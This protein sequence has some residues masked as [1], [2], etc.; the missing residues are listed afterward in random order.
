MGMMDKYFNTCA[1]RDT[2]LLDSLEADLATE[3]L[4]E[5]QIKGVVVTVNEGAMVT[6]NEGA[7]VTVNE[8]AM[9]VGMMDKYQELAEKRAWDNIPLDQCRDKD[10]MIG[11]VEE[12]WPEF[13][14][15]KEKL[16]FE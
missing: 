8:G 1:R 14:T 12:N 2:G 16:L 3:A 10:A 9:V 4:T 5:E 7:M 11:W 6:V 15:D 13:L